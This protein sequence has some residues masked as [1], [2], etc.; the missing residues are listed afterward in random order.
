MNERDGES[1]HDDDDDDDDGGDDREDDG[2]AADGGRSEFCPERSG[3]IFCDGF[4]DPAFARWSYPVITNGTLARST[5]RKRTGDASLRATTGAP[6]LENQARYA[7]NELGAL[8]SGDLWM[9][10]YYFVPGSVVVTSHFSAG[11]MSE[12]QEP[13]AGFS[14]I[15]RA[16]RVDLSTMAGSVEG[17]IAFPRDRWVCVE[18]HVKIDPTAGLFEAYLDEELAVRSGA[19]NSVP[20]AGFRNAEVGIHYAEETQGPVEAF[21]DDVVI[22]R[23]RMGCD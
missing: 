20:A 6:G 5:D 22:G 1:D 23:T 15:V 19:V 9:R 2:G 10:Y 11:V 12:L 17:T 14:L 4:E 13:Y 3:A 16:A 7:T 18:L 8:K 21:V